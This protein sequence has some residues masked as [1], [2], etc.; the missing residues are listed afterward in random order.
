MLRQRGRGERAGMGVDRCVC[1]GSWGD[2]SSPVL[3]QED[4]SFSSAIRDIPEIDLGSNFD[5]TA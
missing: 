3:G 2:G 4:S 5:L 1:W